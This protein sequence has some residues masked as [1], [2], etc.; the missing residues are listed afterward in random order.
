MGV[1]TEDY[2]AGGLPDISVANYERDAHTLYRGHP[3]GLFTHAS[4]T[5]ASAGV[6]GLS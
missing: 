2:D 6:A 4:Q 1:D 3:G 5:M